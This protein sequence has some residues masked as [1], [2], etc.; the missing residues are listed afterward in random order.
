MFCLFL[1]DIFHHLVKEFLYTFALSLLFLPLS[2][3]THEIQGGTIECCGGGSEVALSVEIG[4][5]AGE[6]SED[7]ALERPANRMLFVAHLLLFLPFPL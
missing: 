5:S 6:T 7:A 2:P 4:F 3:E 1:S